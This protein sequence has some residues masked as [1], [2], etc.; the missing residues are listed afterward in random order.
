MQVYN[1]TAGNLGYIIL[2]RLQSVATVR[3]QNNTKYDMFS[4]RLNNAEQLASGYILAVGASWDLTYTSGGTVSYTIRMGLMDAYGATTEFFNYTGSV[5]AVVGQVATIT[6]NNPTLGQL[7][8]GFASSR[9]WV[10]D[11]YD[12]NMGM[13]YAAYT[14]SS[15]GS[16]VLKDNANYNGTGGTQIGSGTATLVS[17]PNRATIIQFRLGTAETINLAYPFGS[18]QQR[19]GPA[20]WP[21]IQYTGR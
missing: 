20:S 3:I 10:G 2:N 13:H 8:S 21:I 9:N 5:Q 16:Y 6:C 11:Y 18:F 4:I 14:I 1:L 19:N 15:S 12:A 17:W 7:L